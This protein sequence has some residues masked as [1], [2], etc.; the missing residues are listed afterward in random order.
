MPQAFQSSLPGPQR[1]ALVRTLRESYLE[2]FPSAD[3]EAQLAILA[4]G[5]WVGIT[6]SPRRG[7]DATL[8]LAERLVARGLRV[9]PHV[10]ARMVTDRAQL[11]GIVDRLAGIGADSLFVVGGDAAHPLGLY[12][13]ALPL[14]RDLAEFDHRLRYVGV[15]AHPE[16][17]PAADAE[18]LMRALEA[19]QAFAN[20]L[21]TQMCFDAAALE[22]WLRRLRARGI[23]MPAWIGLPGVYDR[24]AL[25]AT[26]L[27]LGVGASLRML[28][29]RAPMLRRLIGPQLYRPDGLVRGLAPLLAEPGLG[30]A[31]FHLYCFNRV[32]QSE[33][34]RR[35]FAASCNPPLPGG[36]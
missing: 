17:H 29:Q 23:N 13:E 35:Q 2:V 18:A 25:L 30:I 9:V 7:V 14:L 27:R 32:G 22:D 4:P 16:G 3:I 20:Y 21:V 34:W 15:A 10:A 26:S 24:A 19:K 33:D 5:S 1:E 28:R 36:A 8:E 31:G 11:R 6:C 12:S